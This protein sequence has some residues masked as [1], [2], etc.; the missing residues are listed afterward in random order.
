[1]IHKLVIGG[2]L[3]VWSAA[4]A[5]A[6]KVA[7]PAK[8][9]KVD[10]AA[11]SAQ[12]S[13]T[14]LEA[15]ARAAD[16]LGAA[17]APAAH[18]ALL[19]ALALGLPP[20]IAAPALSALAL[21]PAPADVVAIKRYAGHHNPNVRV[22]AMSA[23]ASYP[24][25]D[26]HMAVVDGLHDSAGLVRTSAAAAAARGHNRQALDALFELLARDEDGAAKALAQLADP[27]L[28]AKIAD[29]LG[30]V[31]D[32]ALAKTLG[33]ILL[34]PD[35]GPDAARVEVVR[36]LTKIQANEATNALGDYVENT[37]KNPPRPSRAEAE[38]AWTARRGGSK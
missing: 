30:Q 38:K 2:V 10:V 27:E 29:H 33:A 28:A 37:P 18:D 21:H 4:A 7:G 35:F 31:P 16:A 3:V 15:A 32:G 25:A 9:T 5:G 20:A 11:L 19:D 17:D 14:D 23:L 26:A 6:P 12:I 34:R 8:Q 13:G 36:A 1:M 22:A 24:G